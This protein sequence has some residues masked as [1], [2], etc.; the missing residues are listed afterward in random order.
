MYL[1]E[2]TIFCDLKQ[3]T[4]IRKGDFLSSGTIK[5]VIP[6]ISFLFLFRVAGWQTYLKLLSLYH[7]VFSDF[8]AEI[9][10]VTLC[11]HSEVNFV[12]IMP[13]VFEI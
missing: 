10:S 12:H 11:A 5:M 7:S 3:S 1:V 8:V 9:I 4:C 6:S 13:L 2:Q